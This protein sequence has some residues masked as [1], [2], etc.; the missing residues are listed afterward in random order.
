MAKRLKLGDADEMFRRYFDRWYDEETRELKSFEA[1]RPDVLTSPSYVGRSVA[2]LCP[3][4]DEA[5][6]DSMQRI[7]RMYKAAENDWANLLELRPPIDLGW[8]ASFDAYYDRS[9]IEELV[10]DSDPADFSNTYLVTVCEFGAVLGAVMRDL[11][12]RVAWLASWPYWESSIFDSQTGKIVPVF[13]WAIKKFSTYGIDDGFADKLQVAI[14]MMCEGEDAAK[15]LRTWA[16]RGQAYLSWPERKLSD[17]KR[18]AQAHPA[19]QAGVKPVPQNEA[20]PHDQKS[21]RAIREQ[22]VS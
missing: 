19:K 12:P 16:G 17:S 18:G 2:E 15:W 10:L 1:T 14:A 4:N 13:H 11:L 8:V 7:Q 5:A 22:L 6:A 21:N 9:R 3:V 20:G